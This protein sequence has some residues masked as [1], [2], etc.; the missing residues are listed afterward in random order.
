MKIIASGPITSWQIDGE[1]MEQA[2]FSWAPNSLQMLSEV[3]KLKMFLGRKAI[4]KLDS[5]LKSRDITLA[6]KVHLDG[7]I[8]F[9]IVVYGSESWTR[10]K[11]LA[12]T[13]LCT[14]N[15]YNSIFFF[16]YNC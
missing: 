7:A 15:I 16:F 12:H 8:T 10:K 4:T 9:L 13:H 11:L 1:T 5:I 6:T 2:L 14:Y 3:M